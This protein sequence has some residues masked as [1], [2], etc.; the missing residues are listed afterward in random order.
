MT[1]EHNGMTVTV[2][3]YQVTIED[4]D[5]RV[6]ISVP[7]HTEPR[8]IE[9]SYDSVT[10]EVVFTRSGTDEVTIPID[11]LLEIEAKVQGEWARQS[12]RDGN[13]LLTSSDGCTWNSQILSLP[14]AGFQV[15]DVSMVGDLLAVTIGQTFGPPRTAQ[16][17]WAELPDGPR[18]CPAE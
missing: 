12:E 16:I 13:V 3:A 2:T 14:N 8:E 1:I 4:A 15:Y 10:E 7:R 6:I 9:I 17:W 11:D 18:E 5:G